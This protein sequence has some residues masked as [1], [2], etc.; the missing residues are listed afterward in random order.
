MKYTCELYITNWS[1][2]N[3]VGIVFAVYQIMRSKGAYWAGP[4]LS[5]CLLYSYSYK[6]FIQAHLFA[7]WVDRCLLCSY[8]SIIF[9][10]ERLFSVWVAWCLLRSSCSL[11]WWQLCLRCDSCAR[12]ELSP[13][14]FD[15]FLFY[16]FCFDL[17]LCFIFPF[18]LYSPHPLKD[19]LTH[20]PFSR[21]FLNHSTLAS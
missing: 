17:F 4:R 8:Y 10:R 18:Q 13:I 5:W 21:I 7:V 20:K 14:G 12:L 19:Y 3:K 6:I 2:S 9:I 15:Y 1:Y 16:R 11:F